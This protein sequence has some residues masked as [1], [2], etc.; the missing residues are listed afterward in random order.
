MQQI[1][2]EPGIADKALVVLAQ[3]ASEEP[4]I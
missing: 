4:K 2:L 1:L 3:T